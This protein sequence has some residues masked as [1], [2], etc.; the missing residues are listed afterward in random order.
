[1]NIKKVYTMVYVSFSHNCE[2]IVLEVLDGVSMNIN[3]SNS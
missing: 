3:R 1:M 2:K